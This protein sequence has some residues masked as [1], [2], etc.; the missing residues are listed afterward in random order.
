VVLNDG[1]QTDGRVNWDIPYTQCGSSTGGPQ[2]GN[3]ASFVSMSVPNTMNAGSTYSVTVVMRNKG[4]NVWSGGTGYY[5]GSQDPQDNANWG[6]NRFCPPGNTAPGSQASISLTVTA[7]SSPGF[8]NFQADAAKLRRVVWRFYTSGRRA[9]GISLWM[10]L[11]AA[12]QLLLGGRDLEFKHLH[13]PI[14]R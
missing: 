10:R 9:G 7:P 14:P 1:C 4:T 3:S 12:K 8:Y 6:L 5:I 2:P 13:L 11:D